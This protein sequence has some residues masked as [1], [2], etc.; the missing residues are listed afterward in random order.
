MALDKDDKD[1]PIVL[2]DLI[3]N[4]AQIVG[5]ITFHTIC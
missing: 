1:S 3:D 2:T 4:K 5:L